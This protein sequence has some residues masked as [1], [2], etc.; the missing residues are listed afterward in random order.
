MFTQEIESLRTRVATTPPPPPVDYAAI[1]SA[2][3]AVLSAIPGG[4]KGVGTPSAKQL[5]LKDLSWFREI[6]SA[7]VS[8]FDWSE[9]FLNAGN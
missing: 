3:V 5:S 9:K 4:A 1:T 2:V 7:E 8:C 6:D